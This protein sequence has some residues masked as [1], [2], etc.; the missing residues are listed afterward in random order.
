MRTV[1]EVR[2]HWLTP[3]HTTWSPSSVISFDTETKETAEGDDLLLTA[4]CWSA[5]W[6]L[7]R[8]ALPT[9]PRTQLRHGVSMAELAEYVE[10]STDKAPETWVYAHNL[11]FD[12][13]VSA[14][15]LRL[16][17]KGWQLDDCMLGSESSF[18]KLKRG[19]AKLILTDSWSWTRCDL[20]QMAKDMKRR[21]RELPGNDDDI[22]YW[23]ARCDKD[24]RLL[25]E[26][27]FTL[28]E[29]W[30]E[31]NLGRW[32]VTGSACGWSAARHRIKARS[33]LVGGEPERS[34]FERL[35][36]HGGDKE[37]FHVGQI[38]GTIV[39]D[40]DFQNCYPR[41]AAAHN[42][43]MRPKRSYSRLDVSYVVA[44]G[45]VTDV[46]ARCVVRTDKPC[47]PCKV[48]DDV[49]YPVGRFET[50]LCGPDIRYAIEQGALVEIGEG[51]EYQL[52]DALKDWANW[53]LDLL[54]ANPATVPPL[55]RRMVK[56]WGR[57]VIGRFAARSSVV[58]AERP[59]EHNGWS[60]STG[61]DLT[62]GQQ[63]DVLCLN[64]IEYTIAKDVEGADSFPAVFA[65]VESHARVALRRMLDTRPQAALLQCN[66][67]GWL[68]KRVARD[69][70]VQIP[71]VP[72]PHVVVRK[73]IWN[74][75][76][77]LGPNHLQMPK[78]RRFSGIAHNAVRDDQGVYRW[79]DWPSFRWQLERGQQGVYR[80]PPKAV[81]VDGPFVRRW[82]LSTGE[83]VPVT[84]M[85]GPD[86]Q[87]AI[88]PWSRTWQRR[89][90]DQLAPRQV[91]AL[92]ELSDER[93]AAPVIF[94][95]PTED[96]RGR[97]QRRTSR[98]RA[99]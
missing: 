21:K 45:E 52:G 42:L 7:R 79:H 32:Q 66:T 99:G 51:Y 64:G 15:P 11:A 61:A 90:G 49:W 92:R 44:A 22:K 37:V 60:L 30:D 62:T 31:N 29:W 71:N 50:I 20:A 80:R 13:T 85:P 57:A 88:Q 87:N 24:A 27:L 58:V 19:K 39:A 91:E 73:G 35:A 16:L 94:D 23:L 47:V 4:R 12:V 40:Y 77:T 82:V 1:R 69:G 14:L 74:D 5:V 81:D 98:L 75:V 76:V 25:D 95:I 89:N 46:I 84:V 63:L 10:A 53:Q 65:F 8:Q 17:A 83:T 97:A 34:T 38:K 26:A 93:E 6:R 70:A 3:N 67:D 59:A 33:F 96:V 55:V 54:A 36:I 68:E 72:Y 86:G 9:L 28:M 18:W 48:G 2:P 78:E 43:P 41:V 56:H